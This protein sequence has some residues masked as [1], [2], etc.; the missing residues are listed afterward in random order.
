MKRALFALALAAVLPMSA[1][2]SELSYSFVELDYVNV[3]FDSGADA[4]GFGLRGAY[5]FG[6]SGFYGLAGYTDVNVDD[7]DFTDFDISFYEIGAGYH[8]GISENTDLI[9]ELAYQNAESSGSDVD[10]YRLSGGF[11]GNLADSFEG[12]VKVNYLDGE[13]VDGDFS[14][15]L[16]AQYK[17][18]E[19][20][21]MT[22]EVEFA[23][24]GE[25]YLVGVRASF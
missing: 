16:G 24:G 23:D 6:D 13:N 9:A 12:L 3:N 17:F 5:N 25:T 19:T 20:W 15:T 18:N 22:G 21:G 1:Q 11:R 4:D 7:I 2:A 8:Y 10:G 14:G